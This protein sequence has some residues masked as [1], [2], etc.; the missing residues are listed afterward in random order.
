MNIKRFVAGFFVVIGVTGPMTAAAAND[1]GTFARGYA[2][3]QAGRFDDAMK[4]WEPLAEAGDARAQFNLGVMHAEGRGTGHSGRNMRKAAGWWRRAGAQGHTRALH[5]L[6]LAH[7]G[8]VIGGQDYAQAVNYLEQAA[9]GG[10]ANSQYTLGKMYHYG[11][12]VVRNYSESARYF[13]MAAEQGFIKAAYNLG[14][15]YR[16]G[17]GVGVDHGA[18]VKWFR[19]AAEG[20][21]AKAQRHLARRLARG[22]GTEAN[23][24]EALM[25]AILA[26]DHGLAKA[27]DLARNLR[28]ALST[29]AVSRAEAAARA[30]EPRTR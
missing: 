22:Q 25:W 28:A 11:L 4:L 20:G 21:Y 19:V 12:G 9:K 5:N 6:A 18:S 2:A 30:F 29:D 24:E 10:F 23:P 15:A 7:I 8:G 26:A 14:K 1:D 17:H 13:E 16:D 3:F 27:V